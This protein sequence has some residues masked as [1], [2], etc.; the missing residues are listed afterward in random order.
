MLSIT[1]HHPDLK[2]YFVATFDAKRW[3]S[4]HQS[5][6]P[7]LAWDRYSFMPQR[8]AVWIYYQALVLVWK[9]VPVVGHPTQSFYRDVEGRQAGR[10][11]FFYDMATVRW[12]WRV[13]EKKS[14]TKSEP[15]LPD[16][17]L[18]KS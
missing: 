7:R 5:D 12:P 8:V 17:R 11:V 14:G 4:R 3:S 13:D 6:P 10:D 16:A 18:A 2:D 15:T 1:V 9:G